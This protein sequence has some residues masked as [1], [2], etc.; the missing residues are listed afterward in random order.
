MV[1]A[2]GVPLSRRRSYARPYRSIRDDQDSAN[3]YTVKLVGLGRAGSSWRS[4]E[5]FSLMVVLMV[6]S[7]FGSINCRKING[8]AG[9]LIIE[10]E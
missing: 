5:R 9:L 2:T 6:F 8:L 10:W 3:R 7:F 4:P 1:A